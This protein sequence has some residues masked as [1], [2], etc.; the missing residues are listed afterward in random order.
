MGLGLHF[1][2]FTS[3]GIGA[4]IYSFMKHLVYVQYPLEFQTPKIINFGKT[5]QGS[6]PPL[7]QEEVSRDQAGSYRNSEL[8]LSLLLISLF[9]IIMYI[10]YL[11]VRYNYVF[12]LFN[13][14]NSQWDRYCYSHFINEDSKVTYLVIGESRTQPN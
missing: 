11:Y 10:E 1:R 14:N 7:P 6:A 12:I 3:P 4:E 2:T 9:F 13:S 5:W 8:Q